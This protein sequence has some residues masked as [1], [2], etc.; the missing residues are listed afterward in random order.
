M[1]ASARWQIAEYTVGCALAV[2]SQRFCK[3][4]SNFYLE[5]QALWI[6]AGFW[7]TFGN[8]K[9]ALFLLNSARECLSLC[10]MSGGNWDLS[11]LNTEGETYLRKSEYN[12]AR[13]IF[14]KISQST[15]PRQ[16][17][18]RHAFALLGIA[19]ADTRIGSI[20]NDVQ[21]NLITA[22]MLFS[23][24]GYL[25]GVNTC[26]MHLASLRLA[27]G[28]YSTAK[29]MFQQCLKWSWGK[30]IQVST[31]CLGEMG[32]IVS[33]PITDF[34]WSSTYTLIYLSFAC[35]SKHTYD[36]YNALHCV[37]DLFLLEG[38]E[39]TAESLFN[40]AL[41]GFTAMDVHHSRATCM[42]CLGDIMKRQGN[43]DKAELLWM[44]ARSLFER[45]VQ[46]K[47]VAQVDVRLA[48]IR[49]DGE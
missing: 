32:N 37:G 14:V 13:S 30:D 15:S 42:Q 6:E 19:K 29:E 17:I 41:Q 28:S 43:L 24:I 25:G 21:H 7:V 35:K 2:E 47:A 23:S 49:K 44:E 34:D 4:A 38:D 9:H 8:Y 45:S 11:I 18:F 48:T 40:V 12:V 22:K 20:G 33:W 3:L 31:Y 36:V 1:L 10:G 39:G 46:V 27:E 16:D 26:E 5:G